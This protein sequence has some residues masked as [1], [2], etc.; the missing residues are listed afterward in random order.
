MWDQRFDR[1]DY[2]YGTEP[3]QFLAAQTERLRPGQRALVVADGEGR[4][5]VH[6]ATL[7]LEVTAMDSSG[8]ALTKARKL[9]AASGV[10]VDFHQADLRDWTWAPARYDVVVAI[11][12]QFAEPALRAAIFAGIQ[13]TL[14]PGGLLLLHG[15]TPAQLAF[16]SG[17]PPCAELLYTPELLRAAFAEL[18][19]LRLGEYQSEL[20][21]GT[22]H[23]GQ[24][25][26]IDL[27]A[28]KPLADATSA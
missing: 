8:V 24:A 13:R 7:G 2:L 9:A 12:I 1:E 17:G 11:F 22:G 19:I 28:R 18:E 16:H 15:F 5:A 21:E 25:A 3:S 6:L 4:H 14:A 27:V 23:V 10:A 26:L 20:R